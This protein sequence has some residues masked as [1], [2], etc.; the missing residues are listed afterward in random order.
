MPFSFSI[1]GTVFLV[2][3]VF[4]IAAAGYLVGKVTVKGVNLGTAGV[5]VAGDCRSKA[6]RQITTAAGD[7]AG[8]ALAAI[9]YLDTL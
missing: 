6:V 7:G 2:F 5:F 3:C 1:T 8:A 9:R 4:A